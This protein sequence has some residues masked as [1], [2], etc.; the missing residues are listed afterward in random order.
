MKLALTDD[1][2]NTLNTAEILG[3]YLYQDN[4]KFVFANNAFLNFLGYAQEELLQK[5][6]LEVINEKFIPEAREI[7]ERRLKG[8]EFAKEYREFEYITKDG[9]VKPALIFGYTVLYNGKPAGL[10][11][12]IDI[13][14]EKLYEILYRITNNTDSLS[15]VL[16]RDELLDSLCDTL[17]KEPTFD[18]VIATEVVG[19]TCKVKSIKSKNGTVKKQLKNAEVELDEKQKAI[20][21][22]DKALKASGPVFKEIEQNSLLSVLGINNED[23]RMLSMCT[24]P[25]VFNNETYIISVLSRIKDLFSEK[26][27]YFAYS[28]KT[29]L[30]STIKTGEAERI[31]TVL[32]KAIDENF[33][34]VVLT[35][36]SLNVV[37][38]NNAATKMLDKPFTELV[39]RPLSEIIPEIN[40]TKLNSTPSQILR[41]KTKEGLRNLLFHVAK[42]DLH[43]ETYYLLVAKDIKENTLLQTAIENYLKRDQLTGLLNRRAFLESIDRFINRAKFRKVIGAVLVI[44]PLHFS[45][46]NEAYGLKAGDRVLIEISKRLLSFL[47][48]YDLIAK[49][50]SER[51]GVLLKEIEREEDIYVISVKLLDFLSKPYVIGKNSI[52]LSFNIGISIYPTDAK[53]AEDLIDKAQIALSDAKEKKNMNI[54]FYKEELK[55]MAQKNVE[56]Q[57]SFTE[58]LKNGELKLFLQPYFTTSNFAIGGAEALVRWIKNNNTIQPMEFIPPLEKTNLIKNLDKYMFDS[59]AEFLS[60]QKIQFPISVNVS[61]KT[62]YDEDFIGHVID[63]VKN[64]NIENLINIEITERMVMNNIDIAITILKRLKDNGI[65]ISIDDF[66]TGYSSLSYL[67]KLPVDFV[68]IDLSFV[69]RMLEDNKVLSVVKTIVYLAKELGMKT[70]AEGVENDKQIE[71][72]RNLGCDYL[73]GFYFSKPIP[74]EKVLTLDRI[75]QT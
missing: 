55:I 24:L 44:D 26:Y 69:K 10:V 12:N 74:K 45:N 43:N 51:F 33:D 72:L 25:L 28:L 47:R 56:I 50:E 17:I 8:E 60:S 13:L 59:T 36:K 66:G 70:I 5:S 32:D 64:N 40:H 7:I 39:N 11:V 30:S 58:A 20:C 42:I 75:N 53:N 31:N 65:G 68:K 6:L 52:R 67:A 15:K 4:G 46:I 73:Q 16:K 57:D 9:M 29:I 38:I 63:T 18:L 1:M 23:N 48:D 62:L 27:K 19:N 35:D 22:I 21:G 2:L 61:P 37:Y 71:I 49:L 54:G 14:K 34:M 3:V 41:V